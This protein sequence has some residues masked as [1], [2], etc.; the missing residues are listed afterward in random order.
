MSHPVNRRRR[1]LERLKTAVGVTLAVIVCGLV[2]TFALGKAGIIDLP[3]LDGGGSIPEYAPMPSNP[4]EG[5]PA[6]DWKGLDSFAW[7]EAKATGHFTK[8]QV[9]RA[10]KDVED[11]LWAGR[12]DWAN[13][14]KDR[15]E[16]LGLFAPALRK[17]VGEELDSAKYRAGLVS[18]PSPGRA[19]AEA[20]RVT[21]T[22]TV[23]E[24]D[25]GGVRGLRV[26]TAM[27]W[28]YGFEGDLLNY[29]DH[30]VL[31]NIE[32]E[33]LFADED[34]VTAQNIGLRFGER[35][36]LLYGMDCDESDKGLLAPPS[37]T[38]AGGSGENADEAWKAGTDLSAFAD[39]CAK[40]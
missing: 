36:W 33:W 16:F 12:V 18:E 10:L 27:V 11:V 6:A 15:E 31:V 1:M 39:D 19:L 38:D 28:A 29:G 17:D 9:E 35:Q 30:L 22:V 24:T 2:V 34:E 4:F 21:G 3:K 13:G 32:Q 7:P 40:G 14:K 20:P 25:L 23:D 26:K 8:R 5:T 37:P